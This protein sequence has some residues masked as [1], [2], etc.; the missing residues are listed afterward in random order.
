MACV[1]SARATAVDGLPPPALCQSRSSRRPVQD[2][3]GRIAAQS[4]GR[5][6]GRC[7]H[8]AR[9][10][11]ADG[12]EHAERVLR[13]VR[14]R[15]A[16][17]PRRAR[18]DR[19]SRGALPRARPRP[20]P[21]AARGRSCPPRRRRSVAPLTTCPDSSRRRRDPQHL[22]GPGG[23]EILCGDTETP[24]ATFVLRGSVKSQGRGSRHRSRLRKAMFLVRTHRVG[25][26]P[27]VHAYCL[28]SRVRCLGGMAPAHFPSSDSCAPLRKA[29]PDE[30]GRPRDPRLSAL[31]TTRAVHHWCITRR[32]FG[33]MRRREPMIVNRMVEPKLAL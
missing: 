26:Q 17:S 7:R 15:A 5:R 16:P 18:A 4:P 29:R 27:F 28:A 11:A 10:I 6:S 12:V 24:R 14:R 23:P 30:E 13:R 8:H 22:T 2:R 33:A 32:A 31:L 25:F 20:Q 9:G 21:L 3:C 1:R 19:P